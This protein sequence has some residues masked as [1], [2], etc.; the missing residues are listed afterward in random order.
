MQD[1]FDVVKEEVE[2]S[3]KQL[4]AMFSH[5]KELLYSKDNSD[6]LKQIEWSESQI[7]NLLKDLNYQL[8]DL[9]ETVDIVKQNPDQYYYIPQDQLKN[10][11]GFIN[12]KQKYLRELS[13]DFKQTKRSAPTNSREA[14]LAN[15]NSKFKESSSSSKLD[16]DIHR[17]N[18]S[19]IQ[20]QYERQDEI[21]AD[22]DQKLDHLGNA[23]GRIK[24]Q[25]GE[26]QDHLQE[27]EELL[28]ELEE[29]MSRT[30]VFINN[31]N[32]RLEKIIKKSNDK[33]LLCCI[34]ILVL[35]IA[36]LIILLVSI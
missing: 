15:G 36:V 3:E 28:G 4:N 13:N 22:Q 20:A 35:V 29:S 34:V 30:Q 1:P 11:Q 6:R 18:D 8:Q 23:V 2:Q 17:D 32:K 12:E 31:T 14:L 24:Q 9:Q 33:G 7:N 26:V 5:W 16:K 25:A 10:R 21:Y 19:F 27:D